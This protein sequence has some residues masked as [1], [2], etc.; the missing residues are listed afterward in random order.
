V[1]FERIGRVARACRADRVVVDGGRFEKRLAGGTVH[2]IDVEI[3]LVVVVGELVGVG[4]GTNL[5]ACGVGIGV[6]NGAN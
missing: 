2:A 1:E 5:F 3:L 6:L 4:V